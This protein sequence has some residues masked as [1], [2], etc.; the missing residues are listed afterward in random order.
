[1]AHD[2]PTAYGELA[3]IVLADRPLTPTLSRIAEIARD[4]VPGADDVSVT[5]IQNGKARSVAF[6]GDSKLAATLDER[7]Y[8]D[9]FGPCLDA[10]V[11]GRTIA[12]A[13]TSVPDEIYPDFAALAQREGVWHTIS[14]GMPT[15]HEVTGALNIYSHG[16]QGPL[17]PEAA[18]AAAG[19]AGYLAVAV[20]NAA[21][22][23]GALEL[24]AQM[25][26]AMASRAV[27]EQAKGVVMQS[28]GVGEEVAFEV[29][30]RASSHSNRKLRDIAQEIV[31]RA[32]ASR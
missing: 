9:G 8:E 25:Q 3:R 28:R 23:S 5:L 27:I 11:T 18:A 30:R 20:T 19:I 2:T 1:M 31:D 16:E 6:A 15:Q 10:A 17:G 24:V 29:L 21:L 32:S 26:Q 22:Y 7:Q 14:V 12:I 13:D 4:A